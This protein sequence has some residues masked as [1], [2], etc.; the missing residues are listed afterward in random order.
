MVDTERETREKIDNINLDMLNTITKYEQKI[1][2][3]KTTQS[4]IIKFIND[5]ISI[6]C[7]NDDIDGIKQSLL[8]LSDGLEDI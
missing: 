2:H 3:L 7:F 1:E 8:E 6:I 4:E 5:K